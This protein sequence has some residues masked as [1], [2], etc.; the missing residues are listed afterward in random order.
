MHTEFEN[1]DLNLIRY[2]LVWEAAGTLYNGLN[3][4]ERDHLLMITSAGCNVLNALLKNPKTLTAIDLNPEQNQLLLFKKHVIE[5]HNYEIFASIMGLNGRQKVDE[6][7][8]KIDQTLNPVMRD[9]WE[10]FF[11]KHP[12]GIISSGKLE[13]YILGFFPGLPEEV[14]QEVRKLFKFEDLKLQNQF[15]LKELHGTTFQDNFTDYFDQQNLSKGRDPQLFKYVK[16]SAGQVFYA[17]LKDFVKKHLLKNNFHLQFFMFGPEEI[18]ESILPP[19]YRRDNFSTLKNELGSLK[20]VTG[21]AMEFLMSP[22]GK[23]IN[24]AGLS[25]IFEYVDEESFAEVIA[26][27]LDERNG[28]LR[29]IY[30]NLLQSQGEIHCSEFIHQ[31]RSR[32]LSAMEDCFYF[33]NV[34]V[35]ETIPQNVLASKIK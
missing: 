4:G 13:S 8:E 6:A 2:S 14:Q 9:H 27:L 7:W 20:V 3:I 24:K 35:M 25:N 15:F 21:E 31:S 10:F 33:Q 16:A 17:R 26:K 32:E 5:H 34:R 30:W 29:I 23:K 22:A 12:K 18:P 1:V 11:E 19:C 28:S